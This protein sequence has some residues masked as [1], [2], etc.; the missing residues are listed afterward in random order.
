MRAFRVAAGLVAFAAPAA[1]PGQ[2]Q[3]Q[4]MSVGTATASRGQT[5][6]GNLVVAPGSDAGTSIGIAVIHGAKPGKVVAFIA[7]SHGTEYASVVALTRLITKIDPATLS[8]TVIIVPLLNVASFEKMVPHINPVD[9]KGMNANYP[10][11]PA[12]TQSERALNL[13]ALQVVNQSDVVVDLHGGDLDEDLRPYSYWTRIGDGKRDAESWALVM[14]FGLNHIIVRDIDIAS[15]G[16]SLGG[17]SLAQGKT[18]IVAEAGRSGLVLDGDVNALITGSMNVLYAL[19]MVANRAGKP[20]QN[21]VYITAGTRVTADKGEMFYATVAR[22][23][24][25]AKGA[26]LGYTTDYVGRKTGDVVSPAAGLITFIR[27]VPSASPNATLVNVA[28]ILPGLP[29]Y[30][31]P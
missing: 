9:G 12:G 17:Y 10:G 21:P 13:V 15:P 20:V 3:H 8:G 24:R 27:T 25:V 11:N 4:T 22:D 2:D 5:V 31:K 29:P 18:S 7:G 1:A 16:R 23:T 28:E 30:K 14:A 6:Y 26:I 19:K